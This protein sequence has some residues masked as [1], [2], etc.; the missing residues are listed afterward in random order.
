MLCPQPAFKAEALMPVTIRDV[1]TKADKLDFLRV[2]FPIYRNDPNWVAPLFFE[3]LEHLDPGKN[4]YFQ[5]ADVQLF[6][7]EEGGRPVGRISAQIDRLH[8][9][10]HADDTGMFGFLE[11]PDDPAIFA[12]LL[13]TAGNWLKTRGMKRVRGPFSFSINDETGLLIDGF[14]SPPNMMMGHAPRYYLPRI[15]EQGFAKAK[16]VIA[17]EY[18]DAGQLPATMEK[19]YRRAMTSPDIKVRPLD[20]KNIARELAVIMEI[21][22]DAWCDNWGYVPF[23]PDELTMLGNNL[24]MLVKGEYVAIAE[25]RGEPAAMCVT[26]PNINDW[27]TGLDGKLLP[28]GWAKVAWNLLARHPRSVRMPLMGVKKKFQDSLLGS[29]LALAVIHTVRSYH[30]ARGASHSELSWILEDNLRMRHIIEALGAKPYKTY[31]VF[32]KSL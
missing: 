3:R 30:I 29:S 31:R 28:F 22:N 16:D 8:L 14:D 25:F 19:I 9:E 1:R 7:A 13:N 15:E 18:T 4:P 11:A 12:A 26:L 21:F 20:K 5:H 27:I 6:I 2:P 32:E 23:T 10:R 17:Y 24:K